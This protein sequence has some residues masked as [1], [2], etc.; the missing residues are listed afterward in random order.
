MPSLIAKE[1]LLPLKIAVF[2]CLFTFFCNKVS[3]ALSQKNLPPK[4]EGVAISEGSKNLLISFYLKNGLTD[5]I[6]KII[7]SGISVTYV[8][9]I[10]LK[11]RRFLMDEELLNLELRKQISFDNLKN[12]YFIY[13]T[14]PINKLIGVK[15][16]EKVKEYLLWIRNLK[17]IN[18]SRL[19]KGNKYLVEIKA[20]TEKEKSS[21]P[22][23]KILSLFT[24][25]GFETDT[26]EFEF[27]Y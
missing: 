7:D 1:R 5:E 17:L 8:F 19:Q 12:R 25:F 10:K 3:L 18:I 21:M 27:I 26:Y 16:I 6:K 11:R 9:Q 14:Y 22:F 23:S 15:D 24:S 13:F 2:L 4:I 20:K